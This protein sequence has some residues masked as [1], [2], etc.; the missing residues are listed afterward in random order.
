[1]NKLFEFMHGQSI[2]TCT[3]YMYH[4][5]NGIHLLCKCL[6]TYMYIQCH[7]YMHMYVFAVQYMYVYDIHVPH[8]WSL[9]EMCLSWFTW[10]PIYIY[11]LYFQKVHAYIYMY[12][13]LPSWF[14]HYRTLY[15]LSYIINF[16]S[17]KYNVCKFIST[18]TGVDPHVLVEARHY[19]TSN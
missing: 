8:S 12:M 17:A 3:M 9:N 4:I 5:Y 13:Y 19:N 14:P 6:S 7:V 16:F 1:M 10:Y 11:T 18:C 15:V 2:H